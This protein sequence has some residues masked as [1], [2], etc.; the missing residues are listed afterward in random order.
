MSTLS[1]SQSVSDDP[2]ALSVP[3][4]RRWLAGAAGLALWVLLLAS[5]AY[6]FRPQ[7]RQVMGDYYDPPYLTGNFSPAE[8]IAG[9]ERSFR[10]TTGE[11]ALRVPY[12]GRGAW[13]AAVTLLAA[14]PDGAPVA[15]TVAFP[16][17]RTVA[18][19]DAAEPRTV[20]LFVP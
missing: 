15:A 9:S 12:V 5:L 2:W 19:P 1:P 20:Q 7:W 13:V 11:A 4:L 10:W 17:G 18:L 16:D 3:A 6:Q 14:H 8:T